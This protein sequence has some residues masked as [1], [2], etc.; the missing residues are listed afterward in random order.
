MDNLATAAAAAGELV[1]SAE[2]ECQSSGTLASQA[3]NEAPRTIVGTIF[4]STDPL[5]EFAAQQ[6]QQPRQSL[7]RSSS[8]SEGRACVV[9]AQ[10]K[11]S[12]HAAF[13]AKHSQLEGDM[14]KLVE[15]VRS[16]QGTVSEQVEQARMQ[17]EM[18]R[19]LSE[20]QEKLTRELR[21]RSLASKTFELQLDGESDD[22]PAEQAEV[23]SLYGWAIMTALDTREPLLA[24]EA[25]LFLTILLGLQLLFSCQPLRIRIGALEPCAPHVPS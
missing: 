23:T 8:A 20:A 15:L 5:R 13:E 1:S 6:R 17:A 19:E 9:P 25:V 4:G 14:Q 16:L 24:F 3:L 2:Y 18:V 21:E 12:K 10:P 7:H 22:P 11:H